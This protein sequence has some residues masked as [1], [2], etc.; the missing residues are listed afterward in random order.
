M[1][2]YDNRKQQVVFFLS[3]TSRTSDLILRQAFSRPKASF[4]RRSKTCQSERERGVNSNVFGLDDNSSPMAD[5]DRKWNLKGP[6]SMEDFVERREGSRKDSYSSRLTYESLRPELFWY[7]EGRGGWSAPRGLCGETGG[8][9][10]R[11]RKRI[12]NKE[13]RESIARWKGRVRL[14]SYVAR[15]R[16]LCQPGS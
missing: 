2:K 15:Q 6:L 8:V 4:S 1:R 9:W 11:L 12:C 13:K 16:Y 7:G 14:R 5:G 3:L 10:N